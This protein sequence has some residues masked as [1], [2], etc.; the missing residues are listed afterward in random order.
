MLIPDDVRGDEQACARGDVSSHDIEVE[1]VEGD[2]EDHG[3]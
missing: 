1:V 3:Q 2:V